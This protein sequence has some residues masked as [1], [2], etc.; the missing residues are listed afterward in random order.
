MAHFNITMQG[1]KTQLEQANKEEIILSDG[2]WAVIMYLRQHYLELGQPRHAPLRPREL[3]TKFSMRGGN[4]YLRL[5][6]ACGPVTPGNRLAN[7]HTP[8][9][10]KR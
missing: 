9:K 8:G 6:F 4:K 3:D 1:N 10:S 5:L 2:D 7:L